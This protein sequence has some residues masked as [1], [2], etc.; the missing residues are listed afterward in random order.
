MADT[1]SAITGFAEINGGRLYYEVAGEGHPL[2]LLHAGIADNRMWDDQFALFAQQYRV[3][4][5]DYRDFG[6]SDSSTE[7]YP[8][9]EDLAG[10]LDYVGMQKAHL[11]GCSLGGR[12][13]IDFTLTYPNRVTALVLVGPGL[14][15]FEWTNEDNPYV[16]Q[17]EAADAAGDLETLNELEVRLWVDGPRRTPERVNPAVRERVRMMNG[18]IYAKSG[19]TPPPEP[20]WPEPPAIHRLGD[21]HVPTLVLVGDE[22]VGD[23]QR[24]VDK[25]VADIPGARK[26]VIHNTAHVPNMEQPEEFNRI[27]LDFLASVK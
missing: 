1:A 10:L 8:I 22:D 9:V 17:M 16:E 15:G 18:N 20:T 2:A 7:S 27:V 19:N 4:R 13:A 21:I 25:V 14:S 6:S 12:L 26:V 23:I 3:L 24:R 11:V 5:F